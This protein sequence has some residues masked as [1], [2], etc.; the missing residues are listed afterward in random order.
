VDIFLASKGKINLS[1]DGYTF[2]NDGGSKS[3]NHLKRVRISYIE[4]FIP[5]Y[6]LSIYVLQL[7][8]LLSIKERI[9]IINVL[10]GLNFKVNYDRFRIKYSTVF[11]YFFPAMELKLKIIKAI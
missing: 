9:K 2:F 3:P 6:K 4:Y 7:C 1:D 10:I 11:E 5:F 8:K